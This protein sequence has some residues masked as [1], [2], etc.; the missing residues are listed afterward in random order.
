MA[1]EL[2]VHTLAEGAE[3]KAQVDFLKQVGCEKIQGYYFGQPMSYEDIQIFCENYEYGQETRREEPVYDKAGLINVVTDIPMAIFYYDGKQAVVLS[4]NPAFRQIIR[5][6]LPVYNGKDLPLRI[7]DLSFRQRLQPCLDE[8]IASGREQVVTYIERDHYLQLRLELIGGTQGRYLCRACVYNIADTGED[9]EAHHI[10]YLLRNILKLYRG[11]YY[12]NP[13]EDTCK[14][15]KTFMPNRVEGQVLHGI[16]AVIQDYADHFVYGD[17]RNRFL[18][19]LDFD[20]VCRQAGQS[21][22]ASTGSVFRI[23]QADGSYHW[24]VFLVLLLRDDGRQDFLLCC[25]EDVW[26]SARDRKSLLPVLATSFGI[27]EL[28]PARQPY[29]RLLREL[30]QSMIHYS[31]IKF[32]GKTGPAALPVSASL[33]STTMV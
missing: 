15:I 17:D 11:L 33:S 5:L 3:T 19:F 25:R 20:N 8:L 31:G 4:A 26:E 6:A 30:C 16:P 10:D 27:H 22:T 29:F 1:K 12:L 13:K 7:E 18:S 32:S 2:G 24:T 14:V 21:Q 23:K 28:E 9:R